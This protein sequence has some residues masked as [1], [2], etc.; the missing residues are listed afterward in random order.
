MRKSRKKAVISAKK[1]KAVLTAAG[2]VFFTP[3]HVFALNHV[4][5]GRDGYRNTPPYGAKVTLI[6]NEVPTLFS[7]ELHF[8]DVMDDRH[9]NP[10]TDG[11]P[12]P[13]MVLHFPMSALAAVLYIGDRITRTGRIW[14]R[15]QDGEWGLSER[16]D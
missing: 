10:A 4:G 5:G 6:D 14:L 1:T 13:G 12:L 3:F 9:V 7:V 2:T 8:H 16:D 11:S 15:Y